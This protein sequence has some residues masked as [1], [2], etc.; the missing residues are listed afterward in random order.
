MLLTPLT[1]RL[2]EIR[3]LGWKPHV[4][5]T[6][7]Y[8]VALLVLLSMGPSLQLYSSSVISSRA[9]T[10][11]EMAFQNSIVAFPDFFAWLV[12]S[13]GWPAVAQ[14]GIVTL[15]LMLARDRKG[16]LSAAIVATFI[17]LFGSDLVLRY[18]D[19]STSMTANFVCD[20]L[21]SLMI[22]VLMLIA[23][24]VTAALERTNAIVPTLREIAAPGAVVAGALVSSALAYC[25]IFFLYQPLEDHFEASVHAPAS[26]AMVVG[27]DLTKS[28]TRAK[29]QITDGTAADV[30]VK[31]LEKGSGV[32]KFSWRAAKGERADLK[33]TFLDGCIQDDIRDFKA[34]LVLK[35]VHSLE[36][37]VDKGS[38]FW[39]VPR[40]GIQSLAFSPEVGPNFFWLAKGKEE[41]VFDMSF[42]GI[43]SSIDGAVAD[44][45]RVY[46]TSFAN[47]GS[48]GDIVVRPRSFLLFVDGRPMK[49]VS[50]P[51]YRVRGK[52]RLLCQS[53][54]ITRA[55]GRSDWYDIARSPG[56]APGLELAIVDPTDRMEAGHFT[57]SNINGFAKFQEIDKA[58]WNGKSLGPISMAILGG[59]VSNVRVA[60]KE[61]HINATEQLVGIGTLDAKGD[62]DGFTLD[63]PMKMLWT[64]Q[65]RALQTRWERLGS[66]IQVWI[67]GF[68]GA[69]FG[70]VV[71]KGLPRLA[72]IA[73]DEKTPWSA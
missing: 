26:G 5:Y 46:L 32:A 30:H 51:Q 16:A 57:I 29:L 54:G 15:A 14:A 19:P 42:F 37:S 28:V 9:P 3:R 24:C 27:D 21:G 13:I 69:L 67:L 45:F 40:S 41:N 63:G 53:V 68:L 60:D 64:G 12:G 6:G 31:S 61:V 48:K 44:G 11:Y 4:Q 72:L 38:T 34:T 43:K 36:I 7:A 20:L 55:S 23:L 49:F 47:E 17:A 58:A 33:L 35:R 70:A 2:T 39:N 8:F 65:Q 73:Y 18:F 52:S 56:F 66:E 10:I 50:N 62:Q 22:G 25:V 71:W 59:N 1:V